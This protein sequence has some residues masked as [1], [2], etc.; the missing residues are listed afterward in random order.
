MM[1]TRL[2]ME[3]QL[4]QLG[5]PVEVRKSLEA[6]AEA[7]EPL[8]EVAQQLR[9]AMPDEET[10]LSPEAKQE[11]QSQAS[12]QREIEQG[13][14]GVREQMG[15]VGKKVPIFGPQHE[16]L[17]QEA[18]GAMQQAG[19]KLASREPRGAEGAEGEALDKMGKFEDAMKDL[20]KRGGSGGEGMPMPWGEPSGGEGDDEGDGDQQSQEHVEI[21]DAE[22]SRGPQE[23]RKKLLDAMK[24]PAPEKFRDKVRGYYEELVK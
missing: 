12:E 15:E 7:E 9:E 5:Q 18:Q 4:R 22:A 8:R 6:A 3:D 1:Q 21:P 24:Q 16:Q 14:Q 17:L 11:L 19:G 10:Q 20:A 2:N 23:F 13:M